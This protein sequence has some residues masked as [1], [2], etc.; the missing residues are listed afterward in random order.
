MQWIRS[1]RQG[2]FN[3]HGDTTKAPTSSVGALCFYVEPSKNCVMMEACSRRD[4]A[5]RGTRVTGRGSCQDSR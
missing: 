5:G 3:N 2:C 1:V 4:D